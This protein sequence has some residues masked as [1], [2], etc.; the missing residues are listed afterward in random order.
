MIRITR[1][2]IGWAAAIALLLIG[3]YVIVARNGPREPG[4]T[5]SAYLH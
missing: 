4:G 5:P 1:L 3:A 2:H